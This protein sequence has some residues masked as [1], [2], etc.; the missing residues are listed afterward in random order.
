MADDRI[1]LSGMRF[2]ARHGVSDEERAEAQPF[3]V[4]LEVTL[5]LRRPGASDRLEDTVNYSALFA[6]VRE[7]M[8]GEPRHLLEALAEEIASRVLGAF[9]IEAVRVHVTKLR[10][11][12]KGAA[13]DGA[14]VE[15]YRRRESPL[16]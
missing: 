13:L 2:H 5:D 3:R 8:E 7:V 11:P 6:A 1:L 4:D 9:S 16:P 14:A 12:I 15:V 10:P